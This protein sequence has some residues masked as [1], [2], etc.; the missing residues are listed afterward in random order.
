VQDDYNKVEGVDPVPV[1]TGI[2]GKPILA[3]LLAKPI[4]FMR[5]DQEAP[6]PSES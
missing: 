4:E 6:K 1:G 5:E 3:H 2:D